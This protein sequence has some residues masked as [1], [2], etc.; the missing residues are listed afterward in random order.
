MAALRPY[1]HAGTDE[2][3]GNHPAIRTCT[4]ILFTLE[5]GTELEESVIARWFAEC[6]WL[7]GFSLV[8]QRTRHRAPVFG[9]SAFLT[10]WAARPMAA[11]KSISPLALVVNRPMPASG[12]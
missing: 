12:S 2:A 10:S 5:L 4:V 3:A 7:S 11:R 9:S 6:A 8:R 1:S